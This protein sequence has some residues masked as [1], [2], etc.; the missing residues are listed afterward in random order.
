[1]KLKQLLFTL[2]ATLIFAACTEILPEEQLEIQT[3]DLAPASLENGIST[4]LTPEQTKLF[5]AT[6]LMELDQFVK[7]PESTIEF[8]DE[9]YCQH[10]C[11]IGG[12]LSCSN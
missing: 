7:D 5:D 1:M 8:R 10:S 4:L 3:N 6:E 2:A 11:G 12:C 9:A